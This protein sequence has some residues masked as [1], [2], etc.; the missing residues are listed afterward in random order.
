[1]KSQLMFLLDSPW[2]QIEKLPTSDGYIDD[3]HSLSLSY[4]RG[5]MLLKEDNDARSKGVRGGE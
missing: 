4:N 1:M 5:V 3:Y 2:L